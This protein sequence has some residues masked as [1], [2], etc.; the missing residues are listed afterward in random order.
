MENYQPLNARNRK[1]YTQRGIRPY[2]R[3]HFQG[4]RRDKYRT[5][6]SY[7]NRGRPDFTFNKWGRY[8]W[9][10]YYRG[11]PPESSFWYLLSLYPYG[12]PFWDTFDY[13]P[14]GDLYWSRYTPD[15]NY[16]YHSLRTTKK[17]EIVKTLYGAKSKKESGLG[18]DEIEE[19]EYVKESERNLFYLSRSDREGFILNEKGIYEYFE[20]DPHF[21][22]IIPLPLNTMNESMWKILKRL[23]NGQSDSV[24]EEVDDNDEP[25]CAYMRINERVFLLSSS[26]SSTTEENHYT[27]NDLRQM[28]SLIS[29]GL[30][31]KSERILF[32][33][34]NYTDEKEWGNI[35]MG[36]GRVISFENTT[37][38][39]ATARR[40]R[41]GVDTGN[42]VPGDRLNALSESARE[43]EKI[44]SSFISEKPVLL[45]TKE[46]T[47][48]L[49]SY[50]SESP[51]II[52]TEGRVLQIH[53]NN[54][55]ACHRLFDQIYNL[56]L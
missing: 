36:D 16:T 17:S 6:H 35:I 54:G 10:R 4:A 46:E 15:P 8:P 43:L 56:T 52:H 51:F 11:F 9:F 31:Y 24:W 33:L 42:I 12:D 19:G 49:I 22:E 34:I 44:A 48:I 55:G 14:P 29:G 30:Q 1:S 27:A 53:K 21:R 39:N 5:G 28:L 25:G 38:G 3:Y 2:K 32:Q 7:Y 13:Y 50:V 20:S 47:T 37:I 45:S 26:A 40:V 18:E 23:R 41:E